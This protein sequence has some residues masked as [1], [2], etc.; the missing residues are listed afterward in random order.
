MAFN[1]NWAGT[2]IQQ[3]QPGR[4]D[5]S[6]DTFAKLGAGVRGYYDRERKE[7]LE[8]EQRDY[9]KQLW[10]GQ[11]DANARQAEQYERQKKKE[12]A[13]LKAG[14][15]YAD[16]VNSNLNDVNSIKAEIQ[17]LELENQALEAQLNGV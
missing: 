16:M 1:F 14:Q 17:R 15:A 9:Q 6:E 10:Q 8:D 3:I 13:Q 5:I 11:I 4:A 12:D 2:N 7:R